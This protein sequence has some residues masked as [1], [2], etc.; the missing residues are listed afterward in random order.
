LSCCP[1]GCLLGS[2]GHDPFRLSVFKQ[3]TTP[4][5]T[6]VGSFYVTTMPKKEVARAPPPPVVEDEEYDED[7][8][9]AQPVYYEIG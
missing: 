2:L 3:Q 5:V 6:R 9:V 8:Y 4:K 7:Y 1:S